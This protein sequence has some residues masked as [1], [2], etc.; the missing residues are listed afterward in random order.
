MLRIFK[1]RIRFAEYAVHRKAKNA[2]LRKENAMKRK[3]ILWILS[4]VLSSLLLFACAETDG[5]QDAEATDPNA[6]AAEGELTLG[7]PSVGGD[8]PGAPSYFSA[9]V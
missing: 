3:W 5:T 1:L 2:F 7:E 8:V 9:D 4:L 6:S